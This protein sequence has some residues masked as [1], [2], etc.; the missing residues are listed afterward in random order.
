MREAKQG[1]SR[2]GEVEELR[3]VK[4]GRSRSGEVVGMQAT[5]QARKGQTPLGVLL[6]SAYFCFVAFAF[7]R[8]HPIPCPPPIPAAFFPPTVLASSPACLP[9]SSSHR[10]LWRPLH[11]LCEQQLPSWSVRYCPLPVL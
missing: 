7:L 2:S 9:V 1:R 4:L 11:G 8:G 10:Y 3:A 6:V 5:K